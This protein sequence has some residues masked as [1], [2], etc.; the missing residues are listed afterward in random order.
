MPAAKAL[1]FDVFGTVVDWRS[2]IIREVTAV[3]VP[4]DPARFADEWYAGYRPS[5]DAVRSGAE[6]WA[7]LDILHRRYLDVLLARHGIALEEAWRKRLASGWE[8]LDPWPDTVAGL[9]RLKARFIIGTLT[10]GSVAQMVKLAK[11]GGLPWDVIL[12]AELVRRYKPDPE[13][14]LMVPDYLGLAA[15]ECMLV[16]AHAYDLRSA[17]HYGLHTAYV[18]RPQEHGPGVPPESVEPGEFDYLARDF[19]HLAELMGA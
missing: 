1:V 5:L 14:Y 3:G 19:L 18:T 2:S 12:T 7:K 17:K 10:N 11:Y 15:E 4:G 16:A 13:T 9:A 6:P 8:R